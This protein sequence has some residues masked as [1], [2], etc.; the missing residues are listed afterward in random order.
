MKAYLELLSHVLLS[1]EE[2]KDRT[3]VGTYRVFDGSI[4]IDISDKFPLL[5]TKTV[6]F[7]SIVRELLWML[8]G[9]TN[10]KDL[11]EM[12]CHIWDPWADSNGELGP[13]YQKQWLSWGSENGTPINQ[14]NNLIEGLLSNPFSRRHIVSAWNVAD[15]NAMRLPPCH[16]FFQFSVASSG[17]VTCHLYMRSCDIFLGLPFNIAQYTIL[18]RLLLKEYNNR[19]TRKGA[20]TLLPDRLVIS[21]GD[22]H[23]Y[24]N[25]VRQAVEQLRRVPR[26]LPLLSISDNKGLYEYRERDFLLIGYDPCG[27][28]SAPIAV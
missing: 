12:G 26:G 20:I 4:S 25:H 27:T 18:T 21:F 9:S 16:T 11:Q 15:I 8:S 19:A 10:V 3:G 28:I 7:K 5:T 6:N 17:K 1:G 14:F 23:L 13:I 2:S 24:A 22:L